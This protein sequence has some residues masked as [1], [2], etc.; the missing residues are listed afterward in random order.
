MIV[1]VE[2]ERPVCDYEGSDYRTRFWENQGRDY[3]DQVERIALRTMLPTTG[4]T[5]LDVG[6]GFGRL[7]AEY[8][9]Y[10]KVVLLDYSSSLLREAQERLGHDPRFVFVAADWYKMPF[11]TGVFDSLVQVRTLHH[12]ADA[13]AL[14]AQLR[15]ISRPDGHYVLEFANKQNLKAIGRYLLRR[16]SWSPFSLPPIEFVKLNYDFH[17]RWIDRA[18]KA[19]DFYT[20]KKRTVSHFRINAL[21]KRVPTSL[22]VNVDKAIQPT[23]ALWQLTPSVFLHNRASGHGPSNSAEN[24]FACPECGSLL[25]QPTDDL[26]HCPTDGLKWPVENGLYN[27]KKTL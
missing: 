5:V 16:Q 11:A 12:A 27:F 18:L 9:G 26:I 14:F 7:A 3:E 19:A 10:K 13:P 6:A 21:K 4:E 15:R 22:L 1:G 2:N 24:L 20:T 23:G 17:P 8:A 25:E